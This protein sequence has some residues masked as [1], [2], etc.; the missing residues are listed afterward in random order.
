MATTPASL[1]YSPIQP[2]T[3]SITSIRDGFSAD[4][5]GLLVSNSGFSRPRPAASY[6]PGHVMALRASAVFRRC[7]PPHKPSAAISSP[8]HTAGHRSTPPRRL[9][10][11]PDPHCHRWRQA[12]RR[13]NTA[14]TVDESRFAGSGNHAVPC[15]IA[16]APCSNHV[17][18]KCLATDSTEQF[19]VAFGKARASASR[20]AYPVTSLHR[21]RG[22]PVSTPSRTRWRVRRA[23]G[24]AQESRRSSKAAFRRRAQPRLARGSCPG[25]WHWPDRPAPGRRNGRA[26][27]GWKRAWYMAGFNAR[28]EQ[29]PGAYH[30]TRACCR[31]TVSLSQWRSVACRDGVGPRQHA[32]ERRSWWDGQQTALPHSGSPKR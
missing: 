9:P 27:P 18:R 19:V 10:L 14:T 4:Q 25:P 31:G 6:W 16:S 24:P 30:G 23:G 32:G 1:R 5:P 20:A 29:Q 22:V 13:L 17:P 2:P 28:M 12:P 3:R 26:R 21:T 7:S 8:N 11:L 15:S